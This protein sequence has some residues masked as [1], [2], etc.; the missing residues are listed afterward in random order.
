MEKIL[1]KIL[2][3]VWIITAVL[4]CPVIIIIL[5]SLSAH[6]F[7]NIQEYHEKTKIPIETDSLKRTELIKILMETK[8]N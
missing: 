1:K 2:K 8:E 7:G 6:F 4:C 5:L 3:I